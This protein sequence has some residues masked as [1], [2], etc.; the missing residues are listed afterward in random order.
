MPE[1]PETKRMADA[2]SKS[3]VGKEIV[4]HKFFHK[5]LL[6]L[7][8]KKKI[9][10]V[11]AVSKSKAIILRLDDGN[12]IISHNQ[13]YGKW[14]FNLP[15]TVLKTNRQLR[16]E[17]ITDK[18]AVRLW[19]ATD[20]TLFNSDHEDTHPYIQKI[21][22]DVLDASTTNKSI[23][24]RLQNKKYQN[25]AFG[26]ILLDQSFVAGLG[27][28]LRSE[29]LFFSELN[30]NQKTSMLDEV[31]KNKL[32]N[33]IKDVSVRAYKQ[34]G[35]TIDFMNIGRVFGN[36]EN[37]KRL[38]HMVFGREGKPC[39]LCSDQIIKVIYSSRRIYICPTC[40]N[41]N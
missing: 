16:I 5:E 33:A 27:N 34:K 9:T 30:H 39:I 25:R 22:P 29:I 36:V 38:K 19:S 23:L 8:N 26:S 7:N 18:K 20:I 11:D 17:L 12:S 13:L 31:Q 2:I 10:V 41:Y 28:Y 24:S 15:K 6:T 35:K 32:S 4:S 14:T 37:F 40:Q 3:L 1:G 21:G